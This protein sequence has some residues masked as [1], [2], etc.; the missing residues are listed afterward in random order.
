MRGD[1]DIECRCKGGKRR[2]T[3]KSGPSMD[4]QVTDAIYAGGVLRSLGKISWTFGPKHFKLTMWLRS[5]PWRK[6]MLSWVLT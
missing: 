1:E 2:C 4:S 6:D 5:L 3:L